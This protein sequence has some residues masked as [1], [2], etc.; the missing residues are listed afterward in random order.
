MLGDKQTIATGSKTM[1]SANTQ[2]EIAIPAEAQDLR[3]TLDDAAVA[4]RYSAT[5]GVVA[6]AGTAVPAAGVVLFTGPLSSQTLYVGCG[7]AGKIVTYK[8][9]PAPPYPG[10]R[11]VDPAQS[12][13]TPA[14]GTGSRSGSRRRR[15]DR[16]RGT[17][18]GGR[19]HRR[20]H[21]RATPPP[22]A[23]YTRR[24]TPP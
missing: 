13:T 1:T 20:R 18:A 7:S 11:S 12:G 24:A 8:E 14:R 23:P 16:R 21:E 3:L 17:R 22:D 19:G 2:Y 6:S 15:V 5:A 10:T 9:A 4:W